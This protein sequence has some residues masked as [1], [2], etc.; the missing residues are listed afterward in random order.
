MFGRLENIITLSKEGRHI[1][2]S[3]DLK[4]KIV[5]PAVNPEETEDTKSDNNMYLFNL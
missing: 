1:Q 4:K 5:T 3:I 2:T